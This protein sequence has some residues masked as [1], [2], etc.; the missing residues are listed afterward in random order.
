MTKMPSVCEQCDVTTGLTLYKAMWLCVACRTIEETLQ[1]QSDA[2]ADKRVAESREK[3]SHNIQITKSIDGTIQLKEDIFNAHTDAI[4]DFERE[5]MANPEIADD[6]KFLTVFEHLHSVYTHL[7]KVI[8]DTRQVLID[9]GNQQRAIQQYMN[10]KQNKLR[11]DE[12][13]RLKLQDINYH[14]E[15]IKEKKIKKVASTDSARQPKKGAS[16]KECKEMAAKYEIDVSTLRMRMTRKPNES[17][18]EAA[19]KIARKMAALE[20]K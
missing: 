13:E 19:Q 11:A 12:R 15:T 17:L 10:D 1:A 8:F 3:A 6:K 5:I 14:P 20:R 9:A 7:A 2:E 4:K 18:E 16:L